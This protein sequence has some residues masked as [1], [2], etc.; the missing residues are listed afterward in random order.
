MEAR[1]NALAPI[2]PKLA[3]LFP[4]LSSEI[5]GEQLATVA[6]IKR[7]L[8]REGL[9]VHD[10]ANAFSQAETC[11]KVPMNK[12]APIWAMLSTGGKLAWLAV[13]ADIAEPGSWPDSFAST[14]RRRI[15]G[16]MSL[17]PAQAAKSQELVLEAWQKGVHP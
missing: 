4:M 16:G 12:T 9:S 6:A 3:K 1:M 17:T 5:E 2:A 14:V 11:V 8:A 13:V 10:L 7:T 15:V